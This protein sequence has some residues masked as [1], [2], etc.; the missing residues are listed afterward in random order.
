MA[1]PIRTTMEDIR[2]LCNYFVNK[3]LGST[4][5]EAKTVLD[6]KRLDGRKL[7]ALKFWGLLDEQE[8]GIYKITESGRKFTKSSENEE[9]VLLEVIKDVQPYNAII[10]K[11]IFQHEDSIDTTETAAHWGDHFNDQIGSGE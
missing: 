8:N 6:S 9:I 11:A 10:E 4:V 2:D 3:P 7:S 1:L 5:R